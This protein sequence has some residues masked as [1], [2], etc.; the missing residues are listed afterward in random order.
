MSYEPIMGQPDNWMV[1]VSRHCIPTNLNHMFDSRLDSIM[2]FRIDIA[3]QSFAVDFCLILW[4]AVFR[5]S[6]E[7]RTAFR[8]FQFYSTP[9]AA[10]RKIF[11]GIVLDQSGLFWPLQERFTDS[12]SGICSMI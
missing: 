11:F 1:R 8:A 7:Y 6:K 5:G 4:K 9:S 10:T 2:T 3:R 12:R